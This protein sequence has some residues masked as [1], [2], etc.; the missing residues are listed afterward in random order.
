M[1][2]NL[3]LAEKKKAKAVVFLVFSLF[4]AALFLAFTVMVKQPFT[5]PEDIGESSGALGIIAAVWVLGYGFLWVSPLLLLSGVSFAIGALL[6]CSEKRWKL[7]GGGSIA[8]NLGLLAY[9]F[10]AY[11]TLFTE[12]F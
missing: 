9:F 11:G 5:L 6:T 10:I 12:L 3:R 2:G 8:L 4:C 1:L 7:L